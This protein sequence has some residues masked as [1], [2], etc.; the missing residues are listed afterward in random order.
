LEKGGNFEAALQM[1]EEAREKC[2]STPQP[3]G[4]CHA[5]SQEALYHTLKIYDRIL[6]D[7]KKL[8]PNRSTPTPAV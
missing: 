4:E 2:I 3:D 7:Y 1:V 8:L 5:K 6:A